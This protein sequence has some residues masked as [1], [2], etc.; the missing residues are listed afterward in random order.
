MAGLGLAGSSF[1]PGSIAS[2][3]FGLN[4]LTMTDEGCASDEVR[5]T[6]PICRGRNR[7]V[8]RA[9]LLGNGE[10]SGLDLDVIGVAGER[11]KK[12]KTLRPEDAAA[13]LQPGTAP[14]TW[15][16]VSPGSRDEDTQLNGLG[17]SLS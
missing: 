2:G 16:S 12:D 14:A 10:S 5:E 9:N 13:E 1:A 8:V 3:C 11:K 6:I 7:D 17:L 4:C 15:E